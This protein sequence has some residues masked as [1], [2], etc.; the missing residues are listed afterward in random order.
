MFAFRQPPT[1]AVLMPSA[2]WY[3]GGNATVSIS[4]FASSMSPATSLPREKLPA[5]HAG[6]ALANQPWIK[7]PTTT[8]ARDG[9]GPLYNARTC[10]ACHIN[11]GRGLLPTNDNILAASV[12]RLSISGTDVDAQA[13]IT[14]HPVYGDQMQVRSVALADQLALTPEQVGAGAEEEAPAE[15]KVYLHWLESDF[16]YPDGA[17][18]TLREPK[19]LIQSLGYGALGNNV[20]LSLRNA[21][22][23]HGVGLIELIPDASIESLEDPEDRDGDGISGRQNLVWNRSESRTAPGRFGWKANLPDL[24]HTVAA[25]FAKDLGISNPLFPESQCTLSQVRCRQ[26]ASGADGDEGVELSSDLLQLV[27]DFTAN[28]GVPEARPLD[29]ALHKRGAHLFESVGCAACHHPTYLTGQSRSYPHLSDQEI[30]PYSD[31]LLHDMGAAL[32]DER[33]DY[34][35]NGREWRT[36]PLWSIG[37]AQSIN[38]APNFLHDGRARSVEEAILWHDGEAAASREQFADLPSVQRETLILFVKSL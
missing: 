21:P 33:D 26:M 29:E 17:S 22:A 7:A 18:V 32:A 36:P 11:G 13:G 3:P 34:L 27:A 8:T 28:L 16:I 2:H 38:G 10:L 6:K 12:L 19:P 25:A 5:F 31:F 9:L 14:A 4:P 1:I 20:A 15:A 24:A 23:I 30:W 37:L 35:A